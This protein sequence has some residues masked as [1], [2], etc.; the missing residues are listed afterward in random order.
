MTFVS[1]IANTLVQLQAKPVLYPL[2]K[3]VMGCNTPK[4]LVVRNQ[5]EM[6][7]VATGQ[8][9]GTICFFGS[10]IVLDRILKPLY[11]SILRHPHL[12]PNPKAALEWTRLGKSF[13]IYSLQGA[14][15]WAVPFFRNF[16]TSRRSG[17]HN[18]IQMVGVQRKPDVIN[19]Q[20]LKEKQA[21][22]LGMVRNIVT[23]GV[24]ASALSIGASIYA[25]RKGLAINKP[26]AFLLKHLG[27]GGGSFKNYPRWAEF[28]FIAVASY[29]GWIHATRDKFELKEQLLQFGSFLFGWFVPPLLF[30]RYFK[31]RLR[32]LL[33]N[34]ALF[35]KVMGTNAQGQLNSKLNI[36]NI[37][38]FLA[39]SPALKQAEAL[40]VYEF[41]AGM[42]VS[43]VLLATLPQLLNFKLTKKRV[44]RSHLPNLP[45][46]QI[47]YPRFSPTVPLQ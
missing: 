9:G 47:P 29:V 31:G 17:T 45:Q 19:L 5:N 37:R 12:L 39:K 10:G 7:D 41:A 32:S 26:A 3:E 18:F 24:I 30:E 8:F 38:K 4:T 43:V 35:K 46:P 13:G 6:L 2:I 22:S 23:G 33:K 1:S 27:L 21:Y 20:K 15:Y 44:A 36:S 34:E 40:A 16:L 42:G 25:I 14:L 28:F 11:Q